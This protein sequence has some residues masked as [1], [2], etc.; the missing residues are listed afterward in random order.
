MNSL[1]GRLRQPALA[2]TTSA[3]ARVRDLDAETRT[4]ELAQVG[5]GEAGRWRELAASALEP[6]PFFEP[7]F[8]QPL[9]AA[10]TDAG[11]GLLVARRG[12]EW[13]AAMPVRRT[14]TW[15]RIPL[16]GTTSWKSSYTY[17]GTPLLHRERALEGARALLAQVVRG[18]HYF[19]LELLDRDGP[20]A[21]ALH[22]AAAELGF[23]VTIVRSYERAA[24]HRRLDP[25]DYLDCKPKHRR[26]MRR[27]RDRLAEALGTP[28]EVADEAGSEDAVS[29]FLRL[30]A[31]GWKRDK[32][33]ALATLPGHDEMFRRVCRSFAAQG[34]LQLLVL[35]AGDRA[36]AAKCNLLAGQGAFCFKIGFDHEWA[37]FSPGIQLELANIEHFHENPRLDWMDSCAEPTNAMINRLWPDRR[38]IE[39]AAVT[40]GGTGRAAERLF[41][42]AAQTRDLIKGGT[43]L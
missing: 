13:I 4:L 31:S 17:L 15:R 8:V 6:N 19:G 39:V 38:P 41:R 36:L 25:S 12:R 16:A 30:E 32:G 29:E 21:A 1:M 9:S 7:E 10:T 40:G 20:A 24:L 23:G 43:D 2:H 5:P 35:R 27:L 34:R 42:A 3:P 14:A 11:T 37:R 22:Q 18:R 28:I 26:E 33:T